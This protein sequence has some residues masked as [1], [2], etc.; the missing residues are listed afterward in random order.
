MRGI[1]TACAHYLEAVGLDASAFE[2]EIH[3]LILDSEPEPEW[4]PLTKHEGIGARKPEVPPPRPGGPSTSALT[5][6]LIDD[7]DTLRAY[8]AEKARRT[9]EAKAMRRKKLIEN[10]AIGAVIGAIFALTVFFT[11][12]MF[13]HTWHIITDFWGW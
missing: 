7:P 10:I 6:A 1:S 13:A 12:P 3:T 11:V 9:P 2:T 4:P 5:M 8:Y